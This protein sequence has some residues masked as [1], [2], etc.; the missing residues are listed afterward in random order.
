MADPTSHTRARRAA[1]VSGLALLLGGTTLASAPSVLA[2]VQQSVVLTSISVQGNE[3]IDSETVLSYL[4]I[5]VGDTVDP[6]KL[7]VALKTLFRTDLFSDVK[8]DLDGSTLVVRV[9][10]NPVINQVLFEGNS[11]LKTDKLQDEVQIRPRGVFTRA[12]VE[13]DVGRIVELYRRSGRISAT[14]TPKIV[15]LPQRRVDLIFE[16]HEGPKSGI[17]RVNFLGNKQFSGSDLRG[18]VIT[19]ESAWYRFFSSNDNYDPDRIEYDREQLRK[20]YRNRGFYDFRVISS[21]AE[22]APDRNGFAVTYALDEGERYR[23]GNLTVKS[24]L[25][26]L[27]PDIMRL[28]LPIHSGQI[29]EDQKIESAT[30]NLTFAAGAAGFAFVDVRPHYTANPVKHTVDVEFDIKEG[31]RVY[32]GRIDVVGNTATLDSVIRR[33]LLVA[34]GDA[35]NRALVDRSKANVRALGFFKDVDVTNVPSSEPDRTNLLVKVTEQ[36]TGQLSFS[37]G[38]STVDKLVTDIS[39]NQ[40]NFRGRGQNLGLRIS[41]GTL[42]QQIDVSFTEPHFLNRD[43]QAGW[44]V[45]AYKYN[46]FQYSDYNTTSA[47]AVF[48]VGFPL[49]S[50]AS[51]TTRYTIRTDDV[52]VQNSVCIPGEEAVSI[53]LCQERG[54][55]LT[56]KLGYTLSYDR[57][58]DSRNPTRGFFVT[59]SQDIAGAGGDVHYVQSTANAGW[60]HGWGKSWVLAVTGVAGYVDGWNGDS[61]RIA[62][63]FYPGGDD[64]RGFQIAG[65][66]P[67]DLQFGDALGGKLKAIGTV[68]ETIPTGLPAQYGIKLAAFMDFGTA[69]LLDKR[70]KTNP[71]TGTPLTTVVDDLYFR[72]TAGISVF[73]KSPMGPL[74]FDFSKIIRKDYYDKTEL[75]RFSTA[76]TF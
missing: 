49:T 22:L 12:K 34:E 46:F 48:R 43:L 39:I 42:R 44:D 29:Y 55:Y 69:G 9:V 56:S 45:Y 75:F 70:D 72:A 68:E 4:P 18:V 10:E 40:S 38:Y 53:V 13:E 60:Y 15:E 21:V 8:L 65:I 20:Y 74:R 76:T 33:R 11:N 16:I 71:D 32:I 31:P 23:F 54:A 14:V 50:N 66:G 26:K 6:Q 25:K 5:S 3:R 47:G 59:L 28:L 30:D 17:L 61:I 36:P 37:A 1:L 62:D 24:D 19:K 2:Q 73:W 7:D 52:I 41:A 67:R 64:F 51:L 63:R 58:N 27:N 35:Y 57:R